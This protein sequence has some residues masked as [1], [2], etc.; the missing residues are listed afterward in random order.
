MMN[1]ILVVGTIVKI[2]SND[3]TI[4]TVSVTKPFKN[5]DGEYES[6]SIPVT[7]YG[8]ISATTMQYCRKGDVIGIKGRI[9][10]E[11]GIIV[12]VADRISFISSKKEEDNE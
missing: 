8:E 12:L 7:L 4:V 5:S 2:E 3:R 9:Q 11:S 6:D 1:Q 10:M